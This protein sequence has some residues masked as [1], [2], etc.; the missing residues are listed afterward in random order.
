MFKQKKNSFNAKE[1]EKIVKQN[2]GI[3]EL[4]LRN[5]FNFS[6]EKMREIAD[7]FE[8]ISKNGIKEYQKRFGKDK[9]WI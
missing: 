1:V 9:V 8:F 4:I 3:L 2:V 6:D 5:E 7:S